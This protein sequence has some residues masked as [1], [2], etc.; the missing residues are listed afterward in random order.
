[1]MHR[2]GI[3]SIVQALSILELTAEPE[4]YAVLAGPKGTVTLK[5]SWS[6]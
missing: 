5:P 4:P 6:T 2:I 1:M 3:G